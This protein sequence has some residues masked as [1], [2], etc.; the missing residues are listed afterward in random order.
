MGF[1]AYFPGSAIRI[2]RCLAKMGSFHGL[3]SMEFVEYKGINGFVFRF[4]LC[5]LY[6]LARH[7]FLPDP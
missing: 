1:R 6:A 2:L 3:V 5:G 4:F 7:D